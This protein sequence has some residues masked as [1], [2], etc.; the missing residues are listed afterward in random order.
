MSED[1]SQQAA[2]AFLQEVREFMDEETTRVLS[3]EIVLAV[4]HLHCFPIFNVA[5]TYAI[6]HFNMGV[7]EIRDL[8]NE[9][10]N[11]TK[12]FNTNYFK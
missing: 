1:F 10:T 11:E 5:Q 3:K 8:L 2:E 9:S 6:A 12:K 7:A 4:P